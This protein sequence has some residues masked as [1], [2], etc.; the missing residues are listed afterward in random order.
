MKK[1]KE[2]SY[3]KLLLPWIIVAVMVYTIA[4]FVLQFTTSVEIS[5]TLTTAYFTFWT[6]EI[7][8][9][10]GIKTIKVKGK[11][12]EIREVEEPEDNE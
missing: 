8:S 2:K 3:A 7:I 4:S 5:P 10:A 6:V 1:I 11:K 9:L 12:E